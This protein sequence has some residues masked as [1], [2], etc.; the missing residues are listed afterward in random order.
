MKQAPPSHLRR[1]VEAVVIGASAGGIDALLGLLSGLPAASRGTYAGRVAFVDAT[2][3]GMGKFRGVV[4]HGDDEPW[5][6]NL[7]Q[8][9]RTKG[10]VL[11]GKVSLGYELWRQVNGFPPTPKVEKGDTSLLPSQ[12]KPRIPGKLK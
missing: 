2:D 11:L 4:V 7:R 8:G 5:P 9:V 6:K 3:D 10:F 12:K 1:R